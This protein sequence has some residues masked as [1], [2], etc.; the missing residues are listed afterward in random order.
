MTQKKK[1]K[2]KGTLVLRGGICP[3]EKGIQVERSTDQK[4]SQTK[5]REGKRES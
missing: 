4:K 2:K 3:G 5:K 1:K